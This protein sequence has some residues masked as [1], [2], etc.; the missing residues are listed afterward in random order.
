MLAEVPF[1]TNPVVPNSKEHWCYRCKAHNPYDHLVAR[2]YEKMSCERCGASMF[3]PAKTRPW[4][5]G[6][7]VFSLVV[8]V[9]GFGLDKADVGD[10]WLEV[11]ICFAV[12]AGLMGVMML[13]HVNFWWFWSRFQRGK[14][15]EQ[16]E[17]EGRKYIVSIEKARK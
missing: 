1:K 12:F 4:I 15:G 11:S 17:R 5:F 14:S 3:N 2:D 16:L 6:L 9:G 8:P 13:Y 7:L 10:G